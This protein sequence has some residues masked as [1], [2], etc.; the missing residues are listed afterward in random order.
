MEWETLLFFAALFVMVEGLS[1]MGPP[2]LALPPFLP[3]TCIP[4]LP[5]VL[6]PSLSL[7]P[8][9]PCG[10]TKLNQHPMFMGETCP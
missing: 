2:P 1:E 5:R 8:T 7:S 10:R 3:P 4:S 9:H 6:P